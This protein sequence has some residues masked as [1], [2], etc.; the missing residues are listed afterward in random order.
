MPLGE[1]SSNVTG[2]ELSTVPKSSAVASSSKKHRWLPLILI[3]LVILLVVGGIFGVMIF[4]NK[5]NIEN[6]DSAAYLSSLAGNGTQAFSDSLSQETGSQWSSETNT[7]GT[8]QFADGAYH[9]KQQSDGFM[10]CNTHGTYSNLAFEV[11]LTIIENGCGGIVFRDKGEGYFY[12][13][14]ICE[15]GDHGRYDIA[16]FANY[17]PF[18]HLPHGD[19]PLIHPGKSNKIAVAAI[20]GAMTFYVNEQQIAQAQDTMY[21]EGSVGLAAYPNYGSV[22][23]VE[24]TNAKLWTL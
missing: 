4:Q 17:N 18:Q 8:C 13:F 10:G 19:S 23:H 14:S 6:G 21:T 7:S 3:S 20:G 5:A 2:E 24:Y 16:R 12:Y 9:V 15:S 22:A 11:Q 1:N